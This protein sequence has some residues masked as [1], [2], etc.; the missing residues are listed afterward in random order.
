MQEYHAA[1]DGDAGVLV[2]GGMYE[3][4][5]SS[6]QLDTCYWPEPSHR[7]LRG[8]W[9]IEK[10]PDWVPLKVSPH[11]CTKEIPLSANLVSGLKCAQQPETKVS[12][13]C[14]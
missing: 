11:L 8:T 13:T 6:R 2:R 10:A 1:E 3:A 7:L 12:V 14:T 5:L 9:F 4:H